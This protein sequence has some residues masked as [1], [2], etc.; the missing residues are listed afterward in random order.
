L[1]MV[2]GS[3]TVLPSFMKS[4]ASGKRI[5]AI[6]RQKPLLDYDKGGKPVVR[7]YPNI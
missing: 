2:G 1:L 4:V 3:L 7:S 6:L 5:L